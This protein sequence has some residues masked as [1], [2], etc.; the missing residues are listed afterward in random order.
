MRKFLS[1]IFVFF[2]LIF[3]MAKGQN[4]LIKNLKLTSL[5][6]EIFK[7]DN[8]TQVVKIF[9]ANIDDVLDELNVE[10]V[11]EKIVS[12]RLVIEGYIS[13]FKDYI[14]CNNRKVNVQLSVCDG[15]VIV[16]YPLIKNS[17]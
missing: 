15:D 7:G 8:F 10:I 16:G 14:V 2:L 9:D 4:D 3:S 11:D 12:D 6:F 17:F 5:N 1:V 13:N